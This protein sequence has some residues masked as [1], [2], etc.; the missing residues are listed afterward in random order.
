MNMNRNMMYFLQRVLSAATSAMVY[1]LADKL[2]E[3]QRPP[4]Y[5]AEW[6]D[7]G[8]RRTNRRPSSIPHNPKG[9][10]SLRDQYRKP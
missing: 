5:R 3:R 7:V 8:E 4:R 6:K 1:A 10:R 2:N 9:P